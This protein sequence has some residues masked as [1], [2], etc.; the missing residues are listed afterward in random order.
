MTTELAGWCVSSQLIGVLLT[1]GT[2]A[3]YVILDRYE[4]PPDD[5]ANGRA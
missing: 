5:P 1:M 4:P 3:V 2:L